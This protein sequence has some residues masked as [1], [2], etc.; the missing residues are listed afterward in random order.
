MLPFGAPQIV[1]AAAGAR[2]VLDIGCGSARLTLGLAQA[3]AEEVIGTDTSDGRLAQ[4]R[5]RLATDPAGA[6]V[7]LLEAD[8]DQPLPFPDDR[9]DATVSRLALMAAADPVATLRELRRVT[10]AGGPVVS[11]VWGPVGDN[12]WFVLPRTAIG[13]LLGSERA[14]YARMFGRLGETQTATAVHHDAG[15]SAVAVEVLRETLDV[16]DAAALW[17]WLVENNAHVRR[18]DET[19]DGDQ[20]EAVVARIAELTAPH[21]TT[22]GTLSLPRAI[23][24]TRA[25]A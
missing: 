17:A 20:R 19:I 22:A 12:P 1:T 2:R 16:D 3:G 14:A 6:R 5:E 13:E 7:T 8:F 23:T 18:V 24:L 9:F 11:A 15:L 21:R 25:V 10:V 4:G